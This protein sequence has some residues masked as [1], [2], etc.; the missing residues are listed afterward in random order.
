MIVLLCAGRVLEQPAGVGRFHRSP[1]LAGQILQLTQYISRMLGSH[2]TRRRVICVQP[3]S[4]M[5]KYV[6]IIVQLY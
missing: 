4:T 3:V 2:E 6:N 1:F 5:P